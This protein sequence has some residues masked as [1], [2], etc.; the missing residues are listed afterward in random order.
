MSRRRLGLTLLILAAATLAA[1]GGGGE[2][3]R[4]PTE[5][6]DSTPKAATSTPT[7]TATL[8]PTPTRTA[9]PTTAPT[10]TST[11]VPVAL[12]PRGTRTGIRAV[13]SFIQAM[14]ESDPAGL[15]ALLHYSL[16]PCAPEG[17][18]PKCPP[19]AGVG[20]GVEA[21]LET[22]CDGGWISR[23]IDLSA[24]FRRYVTGEFRL[25][26]VARLAKP[27]RSF[28]KR[29]YPPGDYLVVMVDV[30]A[31]AGLGEPKAV[32][33]APEGVVQLATGCGEQPP[34]TFMDGFLLVD[35]PGSASFV[36]PPK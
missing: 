24:S 27:A 20:T 25:F 12:Y 8:S 31:L 10:P 19:G 9:T 17:S 28:D 26:G 34:R 22:R 14:E 4:T 11:R 29:G 23:D 18:Y 15:T 16:V 33:I 5:G 35:Y 3:S 30:A 2:G 13:D 21:L 32:V 36:L 7:R 6:P 1:C